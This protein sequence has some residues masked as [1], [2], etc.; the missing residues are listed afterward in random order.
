MD[1]ARGTLNVYHFCTCFL[2][3]FSPPPSFSYYSKKSY[4]VQ[5]VSQKVFFLRI[6]IHQVFLLQL[7]F[8]SGFWGLAQIKRLESLL[9]MA[10]C[11]QRQNFFL[12]PLDKVESSSC[13]LLCVFLILLATK[14]IYE[15][16]RCKLLRFSTPCLPLKF[17]FFIK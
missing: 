12:L 7:Q 5:K 10:L 2:A 14:Q 11:G 8:N 4:F 9:L 17:H 3:P 1:A 13:C 15:V 16:E 6:Q